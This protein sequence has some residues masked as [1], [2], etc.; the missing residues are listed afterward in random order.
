MKGKTLNNSLEIQQNLLQSSK[1]NFSDLESSD[2]RRTDLSSPSSEPDQIE[3]HLPQPAA[4]STSYARIL[5]LS[6]KPVPLPQKNQQH[7]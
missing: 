7:L 5:K 1:Q 6:H 2:P 4:E 3:R